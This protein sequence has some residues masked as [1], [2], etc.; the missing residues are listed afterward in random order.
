VTLAEIRGG[1]IM[2]LGPKSAIPLGGVDIEIHNSIDDVRAK[3]RLMG[4]EALDRCAYINTVA[5]QDI[6]DWPE[7]AEEVRDVFR[8]RGSLTPIPMVEIA[9]REQPIA[10]WVGLSGYCQ[11]YT[12]TQLTG[13]RIRIMDRPVQSGVDAVMMRFFPAPKR[14][15]KEMDEPN[16]PRQVHENIIPGAILRMASYD[17]IGLAHPA[18]FNYYRS[19]LDERLELF[20]QTESVSGAANYVQDVD[21][22]YPGGQG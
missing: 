4:T 13:R 7:E 2:R 3:A 5:G 6:Y 17:G 19:L 18:S 10:D 9:F 22:Y 12:Y 11:P 8:L 16:L 20:L 14:M 15:V 1:V 21:S